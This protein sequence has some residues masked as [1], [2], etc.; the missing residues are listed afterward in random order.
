MLFRFFHFFFR[1][2][3]NFWA[4]TTDKLLSTLLTSPPTTTP[5][6]S[7]VFAQLVEK[8]NF[9][10]WPIFHRVDSCKPLSPIHSPIANILL[11]VSLNKTKT[12][13]NIFLEKNTRQ[14]LVKLWLQ[15]LSLACNNFFIAA[16]PSK[17]KNHER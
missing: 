12:L 13:N 11:S 10:C 8:L 9:F 14:F 2:C 16:H 6:S 7:W 15:M 1:I 4:D 3:L 17:S 5:V